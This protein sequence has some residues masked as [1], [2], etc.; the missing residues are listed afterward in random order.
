[1]VY[2]DTPVCEWNVSQLS[3]G[4][5]DCSAAVFH[6]PFQLDCE[7][8]NKVARAVDQYASIVILCS[9]LHPNTVEFIRNNQ[10]PKIHY[11]TCGFVEGIDTGRWMDWFITTADIYRQN[12]LLAQL[13][14]YEAKPKYFDALLGWPKPHRQIIHDHLTNDSRV[15]LTYLQDRTMPLIDLGWINAEDCSFDHQV[16][17]TVTRVSYHNQEVSISQIIPFNVYNETAYTIVAETNFDNDYSF[18]TEKIVKPILA[19]R[20]FVVFSGQHYLKNLRSLGFKTF[21]TVIDESYDHVADPT[22]RFNRA[23]EQVDYLLAQPQ[24]PILEQI[25][26]ITQHNKQ[27]MMSHHWQQDFLENFL[28]SLKSIK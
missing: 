13:K 4:L 23:L 5:A 2:T 24:E 6:I 11:F 15:I 7:F 1:M 10:H 16:R 25:K 22:V 18:Y 27:L 9:E 8:S 12:N 26:D 14:P 28:S 3:D 17:N 19:E 21:S 20:L